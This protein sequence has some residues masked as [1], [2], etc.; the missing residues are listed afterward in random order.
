MKN[1]IKKCK[2]TYKA[3]TSQN[4]LALGIAWIPVIIIVVVLVCIP[5]SC[6]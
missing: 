5:S 1:F 2:Q 6:E 3:L 4:D